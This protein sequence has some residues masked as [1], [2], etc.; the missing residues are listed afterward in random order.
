MPCD[1]VIVYF[2]LVKSDEL[3]P[4]LPFMDLNLIKWSKSQVSGSED[5]SALG[6]WAL[7]PCAG[8]LWWRW[9]AEVGNTAAKMEKANPPSTPCKNRRWDGLRTDRKGGLVQSQDS[10]VWI[11]HFTHITQY[12]ATAGLVTWARRQ[13]GR[14]RGGGS[15][16]ERLAGRWWAAPRSDPA[17]GCSSASRCESPCKLSW[18]PA[19]PHAA[20]GCCGSPPPGCN[21]AEAKPGQSL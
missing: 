1:C 4:N 17:P 21:Q 19:P 9:W 12:S 11:Y 10:R 16:Q 18:P 14:R 3:Q 6:G 15:V 2:Y 13:S 5:L 20:P 8:G 7:K